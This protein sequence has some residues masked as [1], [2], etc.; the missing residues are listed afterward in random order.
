MIDD[1]L[2]YMNNEL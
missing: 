1:I 2:S